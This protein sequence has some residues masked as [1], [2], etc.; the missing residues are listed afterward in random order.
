MNS[1]LDGHN[2]EPRTRGR[3]ACYEIRVEGHLASCWSKWFEGLEIT[4][5]NDSE[6]LLRGPVVDQAA[7]HGLLA[8][9][10]DMNLKLLSVRKL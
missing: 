4:N 8:R 3:Q 2:C 6:T 10:R 5:P 7:L 1:D 9:V